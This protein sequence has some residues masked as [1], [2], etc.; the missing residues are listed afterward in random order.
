MLPGDALY[1]GFP[2]PPFFLHSFAFPLK[3]SHGSGGWH[4]QWEVKEGD[5][6]SCLQQLAPISLTVFGDKHIA[7][8]RW[9]QLFPIFMSPFSSRGDAESDGGDFDGSA[10][11][12]NVHE[13]SIICAQPLG[14]LW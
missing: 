3:F 5:R 7:V 6:Y 8:F 9:L 12:G 1:I 13:S 14:S 10:A 11:S 4:Q 2:F